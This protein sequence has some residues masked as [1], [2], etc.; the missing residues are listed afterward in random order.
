ME[1][2][3]AGFSK[4]K[5]IRIGNSAKSLSRRGEERGSV[6]KLCKFAGEGDIGGILHKGEYEMR[7][8][9]T[10]EQCTFIYHVSIQ[11]MI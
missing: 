6:A 7:Q 10:D 1:G 8:R 5:D 11:L 2:L 4:M 9:N 3:F